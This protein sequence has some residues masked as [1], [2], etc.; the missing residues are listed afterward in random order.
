[1]PS[2]AGRLDAAVRLNGSDGARA[3]LVMEA[4][5]SLTV[6]DLPAVVEQLRAYV[7]RLAGPEIPALRSSPLPLWLGSA[8]A[9]T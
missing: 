3:L 7:A 2:K 5:R 4:K 6:R 1:M 9:V 8:S